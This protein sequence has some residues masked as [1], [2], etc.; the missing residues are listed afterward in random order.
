MHVLHGAGPIGSL[1]RRHGLGAIKC[2]PNERSAPGNG[3]PSALGTCPL[4]AVYRVSGTPVERPIAIAGGRASP[5]A[6]RGAGFRLGSGSGLCAPGTRCLWRDARY[7]GSGVGIGQVG[8]RPETGLPSPGRER[9]RRDQAV[10]LVRASR[11][12][13]AVF[14][15]TSAGTA[16]AGGSLFQP[17]DSSQ[18][19]TNCLSKLGGFLPST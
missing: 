6:I 10:S 15:A 2:V 14:W 9:S 7:G 4:G 17:V 13:S 8:R 3:G 16:G 18:S 12:L 19:R 1:E 11:Y 5:D